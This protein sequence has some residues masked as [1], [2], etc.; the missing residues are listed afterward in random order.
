MSQDLAK[1]LVIWLIV[2]SIFSCVAMLMFGGLPNFHE[3][4][5]VFNIFYESALGQFVT[6]VYHKENEEGERNYTIETVGVFY[7]QIFLL[8]NL[9]LMMNLV[10]AILANTFNK[11]ERL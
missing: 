8:V 11:Y 1:F 5:D 4:F 2:L 10:I 7:H 3:L 9:V 6:E